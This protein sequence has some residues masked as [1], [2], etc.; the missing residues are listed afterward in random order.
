MHRPCKY[1]AEIGIHS[2][3][4]DWDIKIKFICGREPAVCTFSGELVQ[5]N[6]NMELTYNAGYGASRHSGHFH[7][8][9]LIL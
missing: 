4:T 6:D 8:G 9:R 1:Q 3:V 7:F 2:N 5:L